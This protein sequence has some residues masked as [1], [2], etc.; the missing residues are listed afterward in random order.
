MF[1]VEPTEA[2]VNEYRNQNAS[3]VIDAMLRDPRYL[4]RFDP[5]FSFLFDGDANVK[6]FVES[7]WMG[8]VNIA[9][10]P[11]FY[12]F[13]L[14]PIF[15]S[16]KTST[17]VWFYSPSLEWFWTSDMTYPWIYINERE[18]WF[19]VLGS[20]DDFVFL[21]DNTAREVITVFVGV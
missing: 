7:A 12:Q 21:Y 1:N 19:Y 3:Q 14:G 2:D 10:A 11:W 13:D 8:D 5:V 18:G 17:S 15:T 4:E 6:G 9:Q 16:Q 20:E